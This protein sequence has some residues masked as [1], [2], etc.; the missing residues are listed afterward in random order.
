[1]FT[2]R[3]LAI[4]AR[5]GC[6]QQARGSRSPGRR[7]PFARLR[8]EQ[9]EGRGRSGDIACDADAGATDARAFVEAGYRVL[10]VEPLDLFAGTIEV[11]T[12]FLLAR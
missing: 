10:A 8:R 6:R 2:Q 5:R 4:T 9:I 1:M 12:L 3:A 7:G 11:E